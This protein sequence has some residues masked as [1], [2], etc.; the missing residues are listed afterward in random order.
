MR[1]AEI[2][3]K[4]QARRQLETGTVVSAGGHKTCSVVVDRQVRHP[5]YGKFIRRRTK[6]AV[7]DPANEAAVGDI[8]TV[9]PCRPI[10][11]RKRWRLLSVDRKAAPGMEKA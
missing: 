11:K 10:S 8:V 6:L 1:M 2:S 3:Q 7:H 4:K 9:T 5:L